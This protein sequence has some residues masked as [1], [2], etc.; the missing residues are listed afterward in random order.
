[1]VLAEIVE[2]KKVEKTWEEYL[3][4]GLNARESGDMSAWILGDLSTGI[5]KDYGEDS[6]G[7]YAVGIGVA[8]KTLMN[9]R[10]VASSFPTDTRNKYRKLSFSHFKAVA[11]LEKP[12]A[13]LEQ[14]DDNDWPV[15][16][17][18]IEVRKA[19]EGLNPPGIEDTPPKV[20]RCPEC[21][22][23]RMEGLSTFDICKGHYVIEKN[24]F[25]YK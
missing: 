1:M 10:T 6:I 22:L 19:Y 13:W 16:K 11:G 2:E 9:Y 15:E 3:V 14:A 7:K 5:Q 12:E 8:K 20:F 25:K 18:S 23:W 24:E 17:L 4:E 21:G